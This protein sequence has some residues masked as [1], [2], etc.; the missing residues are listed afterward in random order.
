MERP[1][2]H[3]A[4]GGHPAPCYRRE[5]I[6]ALGY[7][8]SFRF[9]QDYDLWDRCQEAGLMFGCIPEALIRRRIHAGCI[10]RNHHDRQIQTLE[11]VSLRAIRGGSCPIS[12]IRRPPPSGGC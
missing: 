6:L 10:A 9:A 3:N 8:E 2:L 1:V 11:A 5:P 12:P 4:Y 7:D